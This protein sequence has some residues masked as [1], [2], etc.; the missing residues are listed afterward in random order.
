MRKVLVFGLTIIMIVS[1]SGVVVGK[2]KKPARPKGDAVES[3]LSKQTERSK[4]PRISGLKKQD[5]AALKH[6]G[7]MRSARRSDRV[8]GEIGRATK[9]HK[10]FAAKLEAIKKLAEEEGATKTA[11]KI[12]ELI[13]KDKEKLKKR[14]AGI[15]KRMEEQLKRMPEGSRG[16]PRGRPRGGAE[17]SKRQRPG[18]GRGGRFRQAP[19][20]AEGKAGKK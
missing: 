16:R 13:D 14:L 18:G 19:K 1:L 12:Q 7:D 10:E 5:D 4:Q 6:A 9:A 8:K 17:G 15:N 11:A 3:K 20:D 2:E